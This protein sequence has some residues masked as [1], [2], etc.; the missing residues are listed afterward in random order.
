M[1][2]AS[3]ADETTTTSASE[4]LAGRIRELRLGRWSL[5]EFAARMRDLGVPLHKTTVTK[6]EN[7]ERRVHLDEL[8]AFAY[9][10]DVAPV[11]LF[12]PPDLQRE[13]VQVEV[14][15]GV[16]PGPYVLRKWIRGEVP[17]RGQDARRYELNVPFA[18]FGRNYGERRD[19]LVAAADEARLAIA[20]GDRAKASNALAE[21]EFLVGQ[22]REELKVSSGVTVEPS[23]DRS[24][25]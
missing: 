8:L 5:N 15:P 24:E 19:R 9:A 22:L 12:V 14:V 11:H 17:L 13:D 21:V 7:A 2:E 18:E 23:D 25:S 1:T 4:L 20:E 6:V 16:A 10:L 3:M